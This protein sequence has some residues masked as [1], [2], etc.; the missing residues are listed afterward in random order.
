MATQ[1]Q[2]QPQDCPT[3]FTV[4]SAAKF[5]HCS[6]A[7]IRELAANGALRATR[8]GPKGDWRITRHALNEFLGDV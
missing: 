3:V 7:K 8:L 1:P 6:H 2:L 5:L 4:D